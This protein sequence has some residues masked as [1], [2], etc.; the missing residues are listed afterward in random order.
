MMYIVFFFVAGVLYSFVDSW[1]STR[2]RILLS[3]MNMAYYKMLLYTYQNKLQNDEAVLYY[4]RP[5]KNFVVN[6][7]IADIQILLSIFLKQTDKDIKK[8]K[9]EYDVVAKAVPDEL[10]QF[11]KKF[12][13]KLGHSVK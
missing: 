8:R 9:R 1:V 12:D 3:E 10:K 7:R 4:L 13:Q 5:F 11:G 6:N 2:R